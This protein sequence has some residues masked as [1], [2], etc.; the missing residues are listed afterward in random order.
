MS[1]G[2]RSAAIVMLGV[3]EVGARALL[4]AL[5]AQFAVPPAQLLLCHVIDTGVRGGLGLAHGFG[6]HRAV[7]PHRAH[8]VAE[9]DREEAARILEESTAAARTTAASV[10]TVVGEGEPGRVV[11]GIATERGATLVVV[12]ARDHPAPRPGPG[13]GSVGHTARFVLDHAPCPV[14]LLREG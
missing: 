11:C 12:G 2:R 4:P 7:T 6:P 10:D 14:L 3:G 8:V 13:P 5:A 1:L 9:A